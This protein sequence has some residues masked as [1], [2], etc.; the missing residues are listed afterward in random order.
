MAPSVT[1]RDVAQR[2]GVST[3]TVSYVL[4][5]SRPVGE[6]TRQRVLA[7]VEELG[8]HPSVV[9]RGLQAGE[10]RMI[11]YSWRPTSGNQFNPILEKFLH[12]VAEA[13]TRYGYHVLTF[14]YPDPFGQV[15]V[16]REMVQSGRVDGFVLPNTRFNDQRIRLLMDVGFPFVAFGRA[17]P[18]WVFPW[19][20][21]DGRDGVGQA[22]SHL[23]DLGHRRIACVA[24][25]VGQ[26]VGDDRLE[27]YESAMAD[28]GLLVDDA[29]VVHC[30]NEYEA[31]YEAAAAWFEL[32]ED[33][34]PTAAVAISDLMAIGVMNAAADAG[35]AIGREFG[36]AGFDDAPIASYLRPPLT[37]VSQPLKEAADQIVAILVDLMQG[38]TPS[39]SQVLLKPC[40]SIRGSTALAKMVDEK[41]EVVQ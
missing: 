8:Y 23:A 40:L 10:S 26:P 19:V 22:V 28:R 16:Y 32:P 7:A 31:A 33:R 18:D 5:D 41:V 11:G 36:I 13:C 15:Q 39:Q 2:A 35:L 38:V 3:A 29:W 6:K 27:G 12:S 37:S 1:I 14:P 24:W 30:L 20:D 34:R 9:A 4:N 25:P 21:V 17:N